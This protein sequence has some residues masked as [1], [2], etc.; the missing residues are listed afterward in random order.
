MEKVLLYVP[1]GSELLE[2]SA[3]TDVFGWDRILGSRGFETVVGGATEEIPLSFGRRLKSEVLLSEIRAAD[4]AA[5]AIPGGFPRYGYFK[6][7]DDALFSLIRDFHE[8][9]KP[10]AA[11]CTASLLLGKAGI[12]TGKR[13]VTY[14]GAHT[15]FREQLLGFGVQWSGEAV[16]RDGNIITS[17]GPA[18]AADTALLLLSLLTG[19]EN[20]ENVRRMMGF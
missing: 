6:Y 12:L 4:Y 9:G 19:E 5:L 15:D 3:F 11:V 8:S 7:A 2:A 1:R 17:M 10:I 13:A 18:S 20:T 14:D 16:T